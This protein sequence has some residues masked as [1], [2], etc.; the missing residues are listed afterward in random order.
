MASDSSTARASEETV[1]AVP[2]KVMRTQE[3][4]VDLER[5]FPEIK[6]PFFFELARKISQRTIS[7]IAAQ[8]AMYKG[9]EHIV[10]NRIAGD[11]V[12]CGVWSGGSMMLAAYA[13]QHF[14][15][16]TRKLYLYDTFDGM[17]KPDAIDVDCL[18]NSALETWQERQD[19]NTSWGYG[20]PEVM[21][22]ALLSSTGY[23][24]ENMV[25]VKGMVEDTIPGI[26]PAHI[27]MLRL[28]TDLYGSTY[29]ELLHGYPR[30]QRGGILI[31]DDYGY[32][33]GARQ[34]ADQYFE[35]QKAGIYLNRINTSVHIGVKP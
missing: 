14:G 5:E 18:G 21:V 16:T 22:R 23:P 27:S 31:L 7:D 19:R 13:L 17:P 11:I 20:G 3:E 34:A 28:D 35:E 6:D 30:L 1:T 8:W 25:F 4:M 29:H 15:D 24:Y 2:M 33:M 10:R 32:F 26:F 12:E 9:I